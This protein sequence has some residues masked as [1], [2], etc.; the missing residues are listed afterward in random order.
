[1]DV[2]SFFWVDKKVFKK[3]HGGFVDSFVGNTLLFEKP[4]K[5]G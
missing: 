3:L 1:M 5:V 4:I 2:K